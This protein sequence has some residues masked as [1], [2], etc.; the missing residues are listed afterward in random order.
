M[1]DKLEQYYN[2][3]KSKGANIPPTFDSFRSTLQNPEK[4]QKFYQYVKTNNF[5]AP[6]T[7]DVFQKTLLGNGKQQVAKAPSVDTAIAQPQPAT[8]GNPTIDTAL[9][10]YNQPTQQQSDVNVMQGDAKKFQE[11]KQQEKEAKDQQRIEAAKNSALLYF[12]NNPKGVSLSNKPKKDLPEGEKFSLS[13][14][15]NLTPFQ[16]KV[17]ELLNDEK[18]GKLIATTGNEG[19]PLMAYPMGKVDNFI[20][21]LQAG[22]NGQKEAKKLLNASDDDKIKMLNEVKPDEYLPTKADESS[23][24]HEAGSLV[25][26]IGKTLAAA[27][28]GA[29]MAAAVP[30]TGGLSTAGLPAL[31]AWASFAPEMADQ[32]Q[33]SSLTQYYHR[34][35]QENPNIS[36]KEALAMAEKASIGAYTAGL[37]E[38]TAM[39]FMSGAPIVKGQGLWKSLGQFVKNQPESLTGM[40]SLGAGSSF[41]KDL[42]AKGAGFN[43]DKSE[44]WKNATEQAKSMATMQLAFN[45]IHGAIQT[46]KYVKSQAAKVLE[47]VPQEMLNELQQKAVAQGELTEQQVSDAN[48]NL[49]DFKQAG[50]K[51][52]PTGN[53]TRDAVVQGLIQKKAQLEESKL[54]LDKSEHA[55]IDK[56]IESIDQRIELAKNTDD[57]I[58]FAEKDDVLGEK[59]YNTKPFEELSAKE[60]DGVIIPDDYGNVD[61]KEIA[62]AE[63]EDKKY[64]PVVTV[65]EK[66]G[67]FEIK[68]EVEAGDKTYTD[69][70]KA[71]EAGQRLLAEHYY[72]NGLD[73]HLK[74]EK[75]SVTVIHPEIQKQTIYS[76]GVTTITPKKESGV[77]VIKPEE[78]TKPNIVEPIKTEENAIQEQSPSSVLQHPQEGV[79]SEGG[80]RIGVEQQQQG[81]TLAQAQEKA[82]QDVPSSNEETIGIH[83]QYPKTQLTHGAID[84]MATEHGLEERQPFESKTLIQ[85]EKDADDLIAKGFDV[86]GMVDKIQN[87][88]HIPDRTEHVV[89]TKY[90]AELQDRL[91][92]MKDV[93]NPEYDTT[94][95][96]LQRVADAAAK[97]QSEK[98]A[99]LGISAHFKTLPDGSY[100]DFMLGE[101]DANKGAPMTPDQKANAL[102]DFNEYNDLKKDAETKITDLQDKANADKADNEIKKTAKSKG[103]NTKKTHEDHVKNRN[104]ARD[105]IK[106]AKEAHEAWLKEQGIQKQGASGFVLTKEMIAPIKDLVSSYV[107][108]GITKLSDITKK[109]Y[110][111]IKDLLPEITEKH[112]HDVIAGEYNEKKPTK[113]QLAISKENIRIEAGLINKLEKILSGQEP[114][115]EKAKVKRNQE[116]EDLK[117]KIKEF[118]DEEQVQIRAAKDAE[119]EIAS[120]MKKGEKA[121]TSK[122]SEQKAL[123]SLKNKYEKQTKSIQE[124]LDKGDYSEEVKKT[125]IL[126]DKEVQKKYPEAYKQAL[127][128]KDAFIK[129]GNEIRLRRARQMYE[130][131]TPEEKFASAVAKGLNVPRTIMASAD[132]SAP[133]R[134]GIVASISHPKLGARAFKFM[135]QAMK[136]EKVYNRWIDDVHKDPLWE[137][138]NKSKLAVTDPNTLH[139]KEQEEA[140]MGAN[141]AEQIPIAG[142]IIKGSERAYVGFL[143]KLRWD[144][145]KQYSKALEEKG[146]TYDNNKKTYEAMASFINS[147]TGRGGMGKLEDGAPFLNALLFSPRLMASRLNMLGL[148]DIPNLAAQSARYL[149]KGLTLNKF[150]PHW[151]INYGFYSKLPPAIRVEAMKDMLK[152]YATGLTTLALIKSFSNLTGGNIS[153]ETDPRSSD[154]GKVVSGDTR[155]DIWGGFQ[156]FVRLMAQIVTNQSK[157]VGSGRITELSGK[158]RYGRDIGDQIES[159]GRG[160]LAPIPAAAWDIIK[161][162]GVTGTKINREFDAPFYEGDNPRE[163]I[164]LTDEL[165]KMVIPLLIQDTYSALQDGDISKL[166]SVGIPGALGVGVQT[167]DQKRR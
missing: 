125:P 68:H 149:M 29:V 137:T 48:T 5:N 140:F 98:G 27:G 42:G 163:G 12:K 88:E 84:R 134:Q 152:F 155:W 117:S 60:K 94:L 50:S 38:G 23:A 58:K 10:N 156:P 64:K 90:A 97:G 151:K 130:N 82:A 70:T 25:T 118:K 65:I 45:V 86:R 141:Y 111:E 104:A 79:G 20:H 41:L 59:H 93:T 63:G 89:L 165:G 87:G 102:N 164:T 52:K 34:A 142:K 36:D 133:L 9:Q 69:K 62:T 3:L 92:G 55:E 19:K 14:L 22:W 143:N 144:L 57:P 51:M 74:P 46:P 139:L 66:K 157:A 126:Q 32:A 154:F 161:G 37:A 56:Q 17:G 96:E 54:N 108:E 40:G 120:E 146:I 148:T 53:D 28:T 77:T 114:K 91:R 116:I 76:N 135:L 83:V 166:F 128:S 119:K 132:L 21:G 160:K 16:R 8:S 49:A 78:N 72:D 162:R 113:T 24:L 129:K 35:K 158:G 11:I 67:A 71:K 115:N 4:A 153:V 109:V 106:A 147:S 31:M 30:E 39:S 110:D 15:E 18:N 107:E 43:V 100:G 75:K 138:A 47:N 123:E 81:T 1:Y 33:A 44:A 145:F 99:T 103:K 150:D 13:Q 136:D 122:S 105:K 112:I 6:A 124:K 61:T 2:Y 131:R 7:F 101:L 95:K 73:E 121:M 85:I 80:E 167:Y 26:P 127:A 159:F